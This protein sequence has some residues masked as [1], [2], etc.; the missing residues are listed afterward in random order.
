MPPGEPNG[1]G[2]QKPP[3]MGG[4]F[5]SASL[6]GNFNT[7]QFGLIDFTACSVR[8]LQLIDAVRHITRRFSFTREAG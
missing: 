1:N 7:L 5:A 6:H 4:F 2:T 8:L 3:R